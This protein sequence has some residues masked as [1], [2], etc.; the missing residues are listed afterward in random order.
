MKFIAMLCLCIACVGCATITRGTSETLV[1]E[2]TPV[3][4]LV[5][6]TPVGGQSMNCRTPC[7]LPVKRRNSIVVEIQQ[8]GYEPV[9]TSIIPEIAGAGAAGMAGNVLLGGLIGVGVDSLSGATKK[10]VPNPLRVTLVPIKSTNP[11]VAG[12]VV[13]PVRVVTPEEAGFIPV[14]ATQGAAAAPARAGCSDYVV[15]RALCAG[16]LHIGMTRNEVLA[17]LG[18]P[19]SGSDASSSL[20]Y[21]HDLLTF[22]DSQVLISIA[23][24]K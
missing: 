13:A 15:D 9:T 14:R 11:Q 1:I 3:G 12:Q 2:T 7:T 8:D 21:E 23:A 16:K 24:V 6:A 19:T 10:L 4:A 18:R 20:R 22:D 5:R 17:A